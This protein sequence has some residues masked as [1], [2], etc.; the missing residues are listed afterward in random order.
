[1]G[2]ETDPWKPRMPELRAFH[3]FHTTKRTGLRLT[4]RQRTGTS[5]QET[6]PWPYGRCMKDSQEPDSGKEATLLRRPS[7]SRY[8]SRDASAPGQSASKMKVWFNFF[9]RMNKQQKSNMKTV[10]RQNYIFEKLFITRDG[11]KC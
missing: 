4:L 3:V 11:V 9:S 2:A 10:N 6:T 1:M 5:E 8:V 7:G